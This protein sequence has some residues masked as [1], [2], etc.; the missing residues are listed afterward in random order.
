MKDLVEYMRR[1][2]YKRSSVIPTIEGTQHRRISDGRYHILCT[3]YLLCVI[4]SI[5]LTCPA[6]YTWTPLASDGLAYGLY[7]QEKFI[8]EMRYV[9][10]ASAKVLRQVSR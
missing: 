1:P 9:I 6:F 8:S 3:T 10:I 5:S 4:E 7:T 2:Q